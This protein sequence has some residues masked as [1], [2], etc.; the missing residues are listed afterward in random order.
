MLHRYPSSPV[1]YRDLAHE[2]PLIVH[3]EGCWL[4]DDAGN[5]YL[6]A[7]GGAF[8]VNVGHGVRE[9]AEAMAGQAARLCYVSGS[10]FTHHAVEELA[11]SLVERS[12]GLDKAYFLTSGSDAV[13][14]ALKLARQH[15]VAL[16]E[17]GKTGIVALAPSYHGNTLLALSASAREH[18]KEPYREWLL[19]IVRVVA[20]DGY[21]CGCAAGAGAGFV[22]DACSGAALETAFQRHGAERIAALIAEPVGGSSGGGVVPNAGYWPRVREICDR[23]GVLLIADEI[24]CGAGRTGTWTALEAWGI[25]PDIVTLGKGIA[26]GYAPLAGLLT[27]RRLIDPIARAGSSFLHAQTYSHHPVACAAGLAT[28]RY[29]DEHRLLDRCAA[30]GRLF[31]AKLAA[32]KLMPHIGDVRGRGLLAGV[33]LVADADTREPFA[34]AEQVA[35]RV[36]RAARANGLVVWPNV[37]H[38]TDGRGDII[39]LAPPFVV[40][41]QEIDEI[42]RRLATAITQT[43]GAGERRPLGAGVS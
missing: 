30:L 26:A 40:T 23:Y 32:L 2:Y 9:I 11:A 15:W 22:C 31:H 41:E 34:R 5:G 24:L 25:T 39:M 17:R 28:L 36:T 14:A 10:A 29:I 38:L 13:E 42:V 43:V 8:A 18:Y 27:S 16:G 6:D 1:F 12:P 3:G 33:E 35:E 21:R 37:G 20:P 7:V 19:E 4:Y